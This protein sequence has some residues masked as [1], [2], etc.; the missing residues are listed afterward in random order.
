[1]THLWWRRP[2]IRQIFGRRTPLRLSQ[3]QNLWTVSR[4]FFLGFQESDGKGLQRRFLTGDTYM[5]VKSKSSKLRW[6]NGNLSSSTE[7]TSSF[8]IHFPAAYLRVL[9]F[10]HSKCY[11]T[12]I[13]LSIIQSIPPQQA[14]KHLS[15]TPQTPQNPRLQGRLQCLARR[16]VC[17]TLQNLE[18]KH[19][20]NPRQRWGLENKTGWWLNQPIW[21][22]CSSNWVHLPQ[23][24]GWK[25][26]IFE[27]PPTRKTLLNNAIF[28]FETKFLSCHKFRLKQ[29]RS[30]KN[31]DPYWLFCSFL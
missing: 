26:K 18:T 17:W 25:S 6:Q 23:F 14:N 7:N 4:G 30:D 19:G 9:H 27:L 11:W 15:K 8:T 24:S 16:V 13:L 21:E 20:G 3:L 1:M 2:S 5:H 28:F 29:W 10:L 12:A 22:I 31:G